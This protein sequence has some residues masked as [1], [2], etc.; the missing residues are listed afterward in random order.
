MSGEPSY[1]MDHLRRGK[2]IIFCHKDLPTDLQMLN[3][4]LTNLGFSVEQELDRTIQQIEAKLA[5]LSQEDHSDADCLLVAVSTH[6]G[7]KNGETFLMAKKKNRYDTNYC[8]STETLWSPF[9]D[10]RSLA[11]KP[12]IFLV[13]ACLGGKI[14]EGIEPS[15]PGGA[16]VKVPKYGDLLVHRATPDGF[17]A[18][19]SGTSSKSYLIKSFCEELDSTVGQGDFSTDLL[20]LLTRVNARVAAET[21][22]WK[23]PKTGLPAEVKQIPEIT[24]RLTKGLYFQ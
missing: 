24:S 11:G 8:Y 2:A 23:D 19:E 7:E 5:S 10:V 17:V 13:N 15:F 22:T 14:D 6:G 16:S 4:T 1:K 18:W 12:K 20:T 9:A 3:S 21:I